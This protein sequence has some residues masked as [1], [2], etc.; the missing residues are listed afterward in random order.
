MVLQ[1]EADTGVASYYAEAFHGRRTSSGEIFNMRDRT[2]AHRWLP[3]N[4]KVLVTNLTNGRSVVVR[5]TDRGPWKKTRLIDVSKQ[6][7][8]DLDMVRSGTARVSIR[9]VDAPDDDVPVPTR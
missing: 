8:I 7:A 4:T 1:A 9:V 3:F 6:A 2:C 5:V